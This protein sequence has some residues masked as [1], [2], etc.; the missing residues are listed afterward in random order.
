MILKIQSDKPKKIK[1]NGKVKKLF[2]SQS[3]NKNIYLA[4]R[5]GELLTEED[6]L[7]NTDEIEL[8]KIISGG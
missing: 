3:L 6:T 2:N 7:K 1:F 8:L 5:N 4:V